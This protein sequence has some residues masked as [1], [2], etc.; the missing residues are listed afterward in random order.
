[1]VNLRLG[2]VLH[3]SGGY[4]G[5]LL[6]F[7]RIGLGAI[8]GTGRAIVSW[9][10]LADAISLIT[11]AVENLDIHGPL[12]VTAPEPV[13]QAHFARAIA[14]ACGRKVRLRI[15]AMCL[16]L[17]LRELSTTVLDDQNVFPEKALQ[18]GFRFGYPTLESWLRDGNNRREVRDGFRMHN[19][20]VV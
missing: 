3:P 4:L 20:C 15:P 2:N 16:K 11:F 9:I 8:L 17:V 13:S 12:N 18:H 7:H 19:G 14:A 6:P 1:M 5:A 10:S